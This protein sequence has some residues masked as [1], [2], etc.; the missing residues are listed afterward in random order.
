[1]TAQAAA[2]T[3][4]GPGPRRE[5]N[6]IRLGLSPHKWDHLIALA[7]NPNVGK[8]TVFNALTGLRQHTGNW[9]GKTVTRAEGAFLYDGSRVK[10]VDLPGTYS[11]QA[12]SVDEEVARDFILFGQPDVTVVVVDA[13]RLERNLNLVLQILE[14]TDRVVVCLNLM[15]EAR[16]HGVSVDPSAAGEGARRAGGADGGASGGGDRLRCC[17]RLRDVA[18]GPR[19]RRLRAACDRT[20]PVWS[21]AVDALAAPEKVEEAFPELPNAK[22]VA[23]RLLNADERVTEAVHSERD[24]RSQPGRGTGSAGDPGEGAPENRPASVRS[25]PEAAAAAG[26]NPGCQPPASSAG[27]CGP[28]FQDAVAERNLHREAARIGEA[29]ACIGDSRRRAPASTSSRLDRWLTSRVLGFPLMLGI[30]A[31]VFWLTIAGA[32]VPSAM[33]ATLLIDNRAPVFWWAS[34]NGPECPGGSTAFSSTEC[35]VPPRGWSR[36]MLPPMAIFFP[37]FTLLEDFGYL[38]RVAFNLDSLFHR[39]RAPTASRR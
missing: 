8:T 17:A 32:N 25:P 11:L 4:H 7:G 20:R 27:P 26:A 19:G 38:P 30:L 9:P 18:T 29:S 24:R 12:G 5:Q 22:W 39:V 36:V 31:V 21:E 10:L 14:I 3:R 6:L 33:L 37:L 34:A 35:I 28:G 15:D 1:M 23:L 2:A 13:T 16:P